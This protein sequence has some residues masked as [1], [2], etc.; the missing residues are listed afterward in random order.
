MGGSIV[1]LENPGTGAVFDFTGDVLPPGVA[2]QLA[3]GYLRVYE[4]QAAAELLEFET[5]PKPRGNA[6]HQSWIDYAASQ[7][8]ERDEA[9]SLTRDELKTRF[10]PRDF[11][12]DAPPDMGV[13][14]GDAGDAG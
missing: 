4:P 11:D 12:P 8:M 7:G 2:R 14:N 3:G 6:S 5:V 9:A 13:S 1:R 10:S